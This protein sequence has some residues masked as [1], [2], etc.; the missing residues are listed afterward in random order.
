MSIVKVLLTLSFIVVM[1]TACPM[2]E[3]YKYKGGVISS[4]GIELSPQ[5]V[6]YS[7]FKGEFKADF[8][9]NIFNT[10]NQPIV[11]NFKETFLLAENQKIAIE[12]VI[13]KF[14]KEGELE[15]STNLTI[16]PQRDTLI[17]LYFKGKMYSY[18]GDINLIFKSNDINIQIPYKRILKK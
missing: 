2:K 16:P 3:I 14:G 17:G 12:N 4:H 10:S 1:L 6:Y 15:S 11:L 9:L 8:V 7:E 13:F 18:K 5:T